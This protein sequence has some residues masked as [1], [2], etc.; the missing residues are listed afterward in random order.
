MENLN[1]DCYIWLYYYIT[2]FSSIRKMMDDTSK[3]KRTK[4]MTNNPILKKP[5]G[6]ER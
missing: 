1:Y 6:S 3:S 2:I 5:R 4:A